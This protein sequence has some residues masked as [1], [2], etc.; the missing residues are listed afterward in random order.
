MP[1]QN[2]PRVIKQ[3]GTGESRIEIQVSM[4][5][6]NQFGQIYSCNTYAM[7]KALKICISKCYLLDI[8]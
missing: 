5:S 4:S 3:Q 1:N 8:G 6:L 2:D 7:N